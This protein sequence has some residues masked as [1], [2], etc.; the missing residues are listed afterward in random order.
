M[1][2]GAELIHEYGRDTVMAL[3][4]VSIESIFL[5]ENIIHTVRR[6]RLKENLDMFRVCFIY[7]L[8]KNMVQV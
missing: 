1:N 6:E 4:S 2:H 8:V 3:D 7:N 5:I